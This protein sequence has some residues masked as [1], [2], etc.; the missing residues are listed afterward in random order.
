MGSADREELVANKW[1]IQS[2]ELDQEFTEDQQKTFDQL[3]KQMKKN[4]YFHF[5]TTGHYDIKSLARHEEGTWKLSDDKSQIITQKAGTDKTQTVD[6]QSVSRNR[7]VITK[8]LQGVTATMVL[9]PKKEQS[10]Q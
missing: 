3:V 2:V 7:F 8:T 5:D 1:K 10:N 6:I 4:A 9:V